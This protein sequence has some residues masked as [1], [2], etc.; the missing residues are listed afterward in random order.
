MT[1]DKTML[2]LVIS[3]MI[4]DF[5]D[6][7]QDHDLDMDRSDL[8]GMTQVLALKIISKIEGIK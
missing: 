7:I 8:Q 6:Y 5:T 2:A 3:N 1:K 4:L